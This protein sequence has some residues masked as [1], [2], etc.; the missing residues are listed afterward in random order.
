MIIGISG[1]AGSGKDTAANYLVDD[2]GFVRVALADKLKRVCKDIFDF[3]DEQ[4]W[5]PSSRRNAPDKR[6]PRAGQ[7]E[8]LTP[9][10]ALQTLGTEWARSCYPDIWTDDALRTAR[11]LLSGEDFHYDT[12]HGLMRCTAAPLCTDKK[13]KGV[14]IP[15]VR[16][17]NEMT[18]IR[19]AGGHLIRM[20]RGT[21]LTGT[22]AQHQ[23]EAEQLELTD[24]YFT[25]V[26]EN[27]AL[28]LNELQAEVTKLFQ[29]LC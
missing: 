14:V 18:R 26:I 12:Q 2:H 13:P 11:I 22:G 17:K 7:D 5:G 28:S 20:K 23:S 8:F 27:D 19:E 6:Y 4:L 1:L 10:F 3:S 16:F 25:A 9:R 15:D 29:S 24:D 21:G